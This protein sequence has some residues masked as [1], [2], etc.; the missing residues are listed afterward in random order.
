LDEIKVMIITSISNLGKTITAKEVV[1]AASKI[2]I[3]LVQ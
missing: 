1:T 3:I 2:Q